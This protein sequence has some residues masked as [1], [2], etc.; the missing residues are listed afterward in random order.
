MQIVSCVKFYSMRKNKENINLPSA[1]S[2][3]SL[4]KVNIA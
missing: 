4:L 1:E 3:Q 2:V